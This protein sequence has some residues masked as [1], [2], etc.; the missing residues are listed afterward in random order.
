MADEPGIFDFLQTGWFAAVAAATWALIL[1]VI[2]GRFQASSRRQ[3]ERL[4][5]LES[6][7]T[8]IKISLA[9]IAG[10]MMERDHFGKYTW[11]GDSR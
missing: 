2:V 6:E 10:R 11:P 9:S 4:E 8:S 5:K 7:I 1:R 3:E